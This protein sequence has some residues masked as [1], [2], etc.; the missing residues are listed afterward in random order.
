VSD[1]GEQV[2]NRQH[3]PRLP[4]TECTQRALHPAA[5]ITTHRATKQPGVETAT[6]EH[7]SDGAE[8]AATAA[9]TPAVRWGRAG[10]TGGPQAAKGGQTNAAEQHRV[11]PCRAPSQTTPK[12]YCAWGFAGGGGTIPLDGGTRRTPATPPLFPRLIRQ[13]AGPLPPRRSLMYTHL[14]APPEG[15]I[16]G[17]RWL[18]SL[19][20]TGQ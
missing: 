7:K 14:T 12:V 4:D 16:T 17:M 2:T 1:C 20:E 18:H 8:T 9:T 5:L 15:T 3:L 6:S 11:P 13:G 10:A 19:P